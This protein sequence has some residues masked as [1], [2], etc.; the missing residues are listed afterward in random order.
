MTVAPR[1][2]HRLSAWPATERGLRSHPLRLL[3]LAKRSRPEQE[4]RDGGFADVVRS[5]L[6]GGTAGV[7]R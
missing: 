3:N 5:G 2:A 1:L 7:K 6:V 4:V